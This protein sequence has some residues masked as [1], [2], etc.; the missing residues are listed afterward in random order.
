MDP[1]FRVEEATSKCVLLEPI[2]NT[3]DDVNKILPGTFI[4]KSEFNIKSHE[5]DLNVWV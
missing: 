2:E 4:F 1:N 5:V 3:H